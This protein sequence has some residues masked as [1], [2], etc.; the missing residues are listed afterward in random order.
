MKP[1]ADTL[2]QP[3]AH[4]GL[5]TTLSSPVLPSEAQLSAVATNALTRT[6]SQGN[7]HTHPNQQ[8]SPA[9]PQLDRPVTPARHSISRMLP[10]PLLSPL[11]GGLSVVVADSLRRGMD[12]RSRSFKRPRLGLRR[13]KSGSQRLS[14]PNMTDDEDQLGTSPLKHSDLQEDVAASPV[15]QGSSRMT[16][17]R[18]LSNTL[19]DLFKGKRQKV[20]RPNTAGD[21]EAGPSCS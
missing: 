14:N 18:S 19:G 10:G 9:P 13:T 12:P 20:D 5:Q 4:P 2:L 16:R 11:S 7:V 15:S 3:S 6:T 1:S 8:Q 17:A 21:E